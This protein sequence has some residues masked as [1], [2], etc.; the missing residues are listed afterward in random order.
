MDLDVSKEEFLIKFGET[1]KRKRLEA[2]L[3]YREF[4]QRCNVDFSDISKIEKGHIN[5]KL[6]TVLELAKGLEIHPKEFFD[7]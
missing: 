7:Y 2:N 6:S 4:A 3:S 5:I 1:L